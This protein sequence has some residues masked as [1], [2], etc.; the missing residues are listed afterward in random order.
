MESLKVIEAM[1][2][3]LMEKKKDRKV[4]TPGLYKWLYK[5][6]NIMLACHLDLL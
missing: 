5:K 6:G 1:Q 4:E 2:K 3:E